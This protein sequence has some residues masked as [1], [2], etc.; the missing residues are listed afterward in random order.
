M[1]YPT[2]DVLL[3]FKGKFKNN[4]KWIIRLATKAINI[5]TCIL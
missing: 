4:I 5:I 2:H 1:V 3:I